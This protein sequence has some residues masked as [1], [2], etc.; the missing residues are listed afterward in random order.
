MPTLSEVC[1]KTTRHCQTFFCCKEYPDNYPAT[2]RTLDKSKY[3]HRRTLSKACPYA[4]PD[5]KATVRITTRDLPPYQVYKLGA[6]YIETPTCPCYS[7]E[8]GTLR[9]P[10][11]Q[12]EEN[13][14]RVVKT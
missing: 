8:V 3:T 7:V 1:T 10:I 2:I 9:S 11:S 4:R 5:K 12:K 14:L 6:K 13:E